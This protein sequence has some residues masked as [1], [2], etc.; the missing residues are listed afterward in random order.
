MNVYTH[1]HSLYMHGCMFEYSLWQTR[2]PQSLETKAPVRNSG[3][4]RN[5]QYLAT[6]TCTD[7]HVHGH[8]NTHT[9]TRHVELDHEKIT[10]I[11]LNSTDTILHELHKPNT[12]TKHNTHKSPV[13]FQNTMYNID[14]SGYMAKTTTNNPKTNKGLQTHPP[15]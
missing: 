7:I 6:M 13:H 9:N 12:T 1:A 2:V 15:N 10:V 5:L 11:R 4:R 8:S 14:K 3:V